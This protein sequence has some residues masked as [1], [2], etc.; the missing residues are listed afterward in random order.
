L[1]FQRPHAASAALYRHHVASTV[2]APNWIF[3]LVSGSAAFLYL[4]VFPCLWPWNYL[5]WRTAY[6][7][8]SRCNSVNWCLSLVLWSAEFSSVV[9]RDTAVVAGDVLA[10]TKA[11][12]EKNLSEV[13]SLAARCQLSPQL[14]SES[15]SC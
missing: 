13:A 7:H 10:K 11:T 12:V 9:K 4:F 14:T 15:W 8:A 6:L 2:A 5:A 1:R 3:R